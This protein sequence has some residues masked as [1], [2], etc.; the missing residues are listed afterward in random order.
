MLGTAVRVPRGSASF[1]PGLLSYRRTGE[2]AVT[3][4]APWSSTTPG[5]SSCIASASSGSSCYGLLCLAWSTFA[6]S[7]YMSGQVLQPPPSPSSHECWG[8]VAVR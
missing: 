6:P 2:S 8:S 5:P 1:V 3:A 7:L 4:P